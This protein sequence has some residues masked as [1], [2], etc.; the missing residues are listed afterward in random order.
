[1]DELMDQAKE[2]L[3][4]YRRYHMNRESFSA[5]DTSEEEDCKE[6]AQVASDKF[7]SMFGFHM[8]DESC[9]KYASEDASL[10][11]LVCLLEKCQ[12][13]RVDKVY[14]AADLTA[15]SD[16]LAQLTSETAEQASTN[17]PAIWPYI[18]HIKVY[19][20]AH[21]LS[22]GLILVDLP[23]LRDINSA[24]R[25]I[26]ERYLI[27]CDEVFAICVEGRAITDAGV[28]SVLDLAKKARL[29]NVGIIC[30]RSDVSEA[31]PLV[32]TH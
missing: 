24:R 28:A 20:N 18:R 8:P 29:S 5:S 7:R 25:Y 32:Q 21:I 2:L 1:M 11:A 9:L 19:S 10:A 3:Y 4:S 31:S 30:T 17:Q 16:L 26:T 12:P 13:R 6:M 15:C 14:F 23:G 22:K 27:R